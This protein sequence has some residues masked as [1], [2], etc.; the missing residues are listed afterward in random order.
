MTP[1]MT[2]PRISAEAVRRATGRDRAEWFAALDGW[3]AIDR[4]HGDIAAWLMAEHRVENWWAQTLTVD[5]EQA[6]GL[7]EPGG[8]RDCRFS[9]GVSRTVA[10]PVERLYAAFMD[11]RLRDRWL[12]G[13]TLRE[14][15]SQPGRSARFDWEDGA[16]RVIVGFTAKGQTKS[17][18]ALVHER[19]PSGEAAKQ[20]KAEWR[21]RVSA[22]KAVL[23][24][25]S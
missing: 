10:V 11:A 8:G 2:D 1:T 19:L 7:R 15:T 23:E 14:R 6:R 18:V 9:A 16:T 22:L 21:E 5:Y 13:A 20:A 3:G 25:T 4:T 12:P 17:H 24:E